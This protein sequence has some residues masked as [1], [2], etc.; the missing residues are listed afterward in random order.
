MPLYTH[1]DRVANTLAARGISP[2]DPLRPEDLFAVDQWHYHG[3]QAIQAAAEWLGLD[4]DSRVLEIG[5]GIGG[6]ARYLAHTTLCH[7]TALELQPTLHALGTELT[8]RC[9]LS[10]RVA[11]ICGDALVY[12]L[13]YGTFDAVV[14]WLAMLH[15]P[16][17]WR[18]LRRMA[19]TLRP[20][21]TCVIE[22]LC[23]RA[24]FTAA[25]RHLVEDVVCGRT[26]TS[27]G[28]YV[29]DLSTAGFTE[30]VAEDLTSIWAPYAADRLANWRVGHT[31]YAQVHG[32]AAYAAQDLFYDVIDSLYRNG[33]L[34]GVRLIAMA[35]R[36]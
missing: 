24:P 32:E 25:D 5:S 28:D 3:T 35:P 27:I 23:Q 1:L 11:H 8:T 29:E 34:G 26:V 6:P 4:P 12:P 10:N 36:L 17:R 2:V 31:A 9:G 16:D 33:S 15:I 13:P 14:S 30:I 19:C 20:G 21:G 18:L 22:D 7:V